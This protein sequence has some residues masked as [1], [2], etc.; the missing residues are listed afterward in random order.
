MYVSV[1]ILSCVQSNVS[2]KIKS[3]K[4]LEPAKFDQIFVCVTDLHAE[5]RLSI[6]IHD[7]L[8]CIVIL[9]RHPDPFPINRAA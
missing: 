4:S 5:W 8:M 2:A 9:N 7:D 1:Y 3:S 6:T